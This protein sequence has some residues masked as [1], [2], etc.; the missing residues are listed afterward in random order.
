MAN[1]T[2]TTTGAVGYYLRR[3]VKTGL[4]GA[5]VE[6]AAEQLLRERLR[7]VI[8]EEYGETLMELLAAPAPQEGEP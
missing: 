2:I 5:S 7:Q 6:D 8:R 1:L 4:F 3:L